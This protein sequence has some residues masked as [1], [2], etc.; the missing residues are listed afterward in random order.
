MIGATKPRHCRI[1]TGRA[2]AKLV[3]VPPGYCCRFQRRS[4][5]D[6]CCGVRISLLCRLVMMWLFRPIVALPQS[7]IDRPV[8]AQSIGLQLADRAQ[9]QGCRL[10]ARHRS[11]GRCRQFL[12][13]GS[14]IDGDGD[15]HWPTQGDQPRDGHSR[16]RPELA[17]IAAIRSD[18]MRR[19][20]RPEGCQAGTTTK[21]GCSRAAV[22]AGSS[23]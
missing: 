18:R 11:R 12:G 4:Q 21:P 9:S 20:V 16:A 10:G 13:V 6:R 15:A 1:S 17:P 5:D 2:A 14:V 3:L 8:S 22:R 7:T 23:S 19:I